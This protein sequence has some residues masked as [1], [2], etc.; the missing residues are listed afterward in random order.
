V[1]NTPELFQ[2][3]LIK[4]KAYLD[5]LA[6]EPKILNINSWNEWTEGSYLEPD[7]IHGMA[8]LNAIRKVFGAAP[9]TFAG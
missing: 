6:N 1:N 3:G 5:G 7:S 9:R 4:A 2:E 8:Y